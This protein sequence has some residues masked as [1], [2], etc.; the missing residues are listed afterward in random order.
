MIT[1]TN[2]TQ[3]SPAGT[4]IP[5]SSFVVPQR[6]KNIVRE[7]RTLQKQEHVRFEQIL[8]KRVSEFKKSGGSL[9]L[10]SETLSGM[11][12]LMLPAIPDESA[13]SVGSGSH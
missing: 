4:Y 3:C 9:Q 8:G 12:S 1:F 13:S 10:L 7:L 2:I 11:G 6:H 5:V